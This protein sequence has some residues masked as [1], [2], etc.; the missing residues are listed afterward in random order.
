MINDDMFSL[1]LAKLQAAANQV[2][3]L[4]THHM[5]SDEQFKIIKKHIQLFEQSLDSEHETGVRLT[6]FG[7]SI[8]MQVTEISYEESVML[9]FKGY[10]NGKMSTLIQ[11][12]N[13][14]SFLLTSIEKDPDKPKR[15]IGFHYP[16]E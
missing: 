4:P 13:Q 2:I 9:I 3:D 14:L 1:N 11:H 6:N 12:I 8:M 7:H 16:V 15:K 10:V 5:W